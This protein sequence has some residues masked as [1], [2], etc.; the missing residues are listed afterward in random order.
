M[1]KRR[2]IAFMLAQYERGARP[3]ITLP[4]L[5]FLGD[6]DGVRT[7]PAVDASCAVSQSSS[8]WARDK[9]NKGRPRGRP[10]KYK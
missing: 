6:V 3:V 7:E 5:K 1:I 4:R 8:S 10:P 9:R 2:S